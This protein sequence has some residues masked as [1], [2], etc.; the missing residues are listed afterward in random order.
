MRDIKL[1]HMFV[2]DDYQKV[3]VRNKWNINEFMTAFFIIFFQSNLKL[4]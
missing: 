3:S 1:P 2:W 4:C